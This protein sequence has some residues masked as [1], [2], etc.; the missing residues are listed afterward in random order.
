MISLSLLYVFTASEASHL[1][2]DGIF[3]SPRL[4]HPS[5]PLVRRIPDDTVSEWVWLLKCRLLSE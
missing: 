2:L 3:S 5:A 1:L 4:M